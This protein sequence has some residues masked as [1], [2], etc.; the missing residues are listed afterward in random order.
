MSLGAPDLDRYLSALSQELEATGST[1]RLIVVGGAALALRRQTARLTGDVDVIAEV[2]DGRLVIPRPF[3]PALEAAIRRVAASFPG[4]LDPEWVNAA[5]AKD[6]EGARWPDDLPPGL[7]SVEW[8]EYGALAVGLA[9]RETLI[10]MKVHALVDRS[11]RPTFGDDLRVTG[12]RVEVTGYDRRHLDD[13]V[14]LCPT[15]AELSAAG[16]WVRAQ[17]GGE[18]GPL[19]AAVLDRVRAER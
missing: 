16:A 10:P 7:G 3:A 19:V 13:L 2:R 1:A 18:I 5:V 6:W 14:A 4:D 17:D 8:R 9:G 11:T 12:G 15:D